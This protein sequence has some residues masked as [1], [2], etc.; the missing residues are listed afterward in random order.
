MKSKNLFSLILIPILIMIYFQI[1]SEIIAIEK[2]D[3]P[4]LNGCQPENPDLEVFQVVEDMPRFPGCENIIDEQERKN[5]ANQLMLE[6]IYSNLKYPEEAF[7]Q[8]IEG[9]TV[10]RFIVEKTGCLSSFTLVRDIGGGTGDESLRLVSLMEMENIK[11]T[12]GLQRDELV[13]VYFNLPIKFRINDETIISDEI[14]EEEDCNPLNELILSKEGCSNEN[15]LVY[16]NPAKNSIRINYESKKEFESEYRIY[17]SVGQEV[18]TGKES[19]RIG[20]NSLFRALSNLSNGT[21]S[22]VLFGEKNE[23]IAYCKFMKMKS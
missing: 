5:C 20:R 21:Y 7:N 15:L 19:I 4:S 17:N 11:W 12:P 22:F 18:L 8:G 23:I 10:V 3:L 14:V 13:R 2:N 9:T 1:T 6:F 16:P